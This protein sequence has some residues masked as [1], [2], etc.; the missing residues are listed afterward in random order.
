MFYCPKDPFDSVGRVQIHLEANFS[1]R[2]VTLRSHGT[3]T[4]SL[5]SAS[6]AG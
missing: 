5:A 4:V 1:F 2:N 3:S 6:S